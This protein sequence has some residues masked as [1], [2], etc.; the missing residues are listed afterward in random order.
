MTNRTKQSRQRGWRWWF[1]RS[2]TAVFILIILFGG[3]TISAGASAKADIAAQNPPPGQLVDIGGYQL[4]LNC[5]GSGSPTVIMEAGL[6]DFSLFWSAVQPE[7][8]QFTQLC[9]YD[10]AGL[11]WSEASPYPRTSAQMVEELHTLLN[12]ADV[13]GPY[14]LVGHSFGGANMRLFA[15]QYPDETAGLILVDATHE[16]AFLREPEAFAPAMSDAISQFNTLI[17]M[18]NLGLLAL[19]PETIPDRGLS[20]EALTQYRAI[21]AS[22]DYF[23]TAV[24]ESESFPSNLKQVGEANINLGDLPLVVLSR[25]L[26]EP[27]PQMEEAE[28]APF[29]QSWRQMQNELLNLS[30]NSQQIIAAESAHYIQLQQ[31]DLLIDVVRKMWEE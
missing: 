24:S 23:V 18:S 20:G 14:L 25:G 30:S 12:K 27:F 11:G 6:N 26:P 15:Y 16:E 29:E 21:L 5:Q 22:T 3:F 2:A 1:I 8:A 13:A 10:R 19:S 9:T 31:P 4:H 17:G 7:I 28:I